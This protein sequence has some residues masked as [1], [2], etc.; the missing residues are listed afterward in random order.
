MKRFTR[1]I[2]TA[3]PVLLDVAAF[4]AL[5]IGTAL[6][7]GAWAWIVAGGLLILAGMRASDKPIR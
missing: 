7:A 1:W 4:I 5:T 6:L 3:A 2:K